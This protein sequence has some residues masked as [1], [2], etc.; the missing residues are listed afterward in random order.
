M[1]TLTTSPDTRNAT[2]SPA[3]ASGRMRFGKPDGQMTDLFGPVP[4][5]AN[6]SARQA[7]GLGLLTS[8]T[9][10]RTST[11]SSASA[12]LQRS[13]ASRLQALM[14]ST[15]STLYRL[16]WKTRATPSGRL[17]CARRASVPRISGSGSTGWPTPTCNAKDQPETVRGLETLAGSARLAG[18]PTATATDS[19]RRGRLD[20]HA[21][22]KTLNHIAQ[23]AGWP[24]P[25][26]TEQRQA[27]EP[28]ERPSNAP[29]GRKQNPASATGLCSHM[30]GH[31]L[32]G[33]WSDA[34]WLLCRDGRWRPV[35]PGTFPLADG[36]PA[37]VGRLRAYGNGLVSQVAQAFIAACM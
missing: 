34:D 14:D 36:A 26:A 7:A 17:I 10:G 24:T 13:L 32:H 27:A 15:G 3:S 18:W 25:T 4:V 5:H 20:E 21:P 30:P 33:F 22:N 23:I 1:S 6:L 37:R 31:A 8:G 12:T 28:A 16:T 35:E 19:E 11:T 2:F 29:A 9:S